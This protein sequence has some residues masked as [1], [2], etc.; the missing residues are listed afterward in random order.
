M[1]W[2]AETYTRCYIRIHILLKK[3]CLSVAQQLLLL[4]LPPLMLLYVNYARLVLK[5]RSFFTRLNITRLTVLSFRSDGVNYYANGLRTH[6]TRLR[7]YVYND[8]RYSK[9]LQR[10][11]S[12][13]CE[14]VSGR[15]R[16]R[17]TSLSPRTVLFPS[18]HG[19][20]TRP[21]RSVLT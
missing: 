12:P 8:R 2:S 3:F 13:S 15:R 7:A 6:V 9:P 11:R 10:A 19:A 21:G 4:L 16:L 20:C 17:H 18:S 5:N 1:F 14:T